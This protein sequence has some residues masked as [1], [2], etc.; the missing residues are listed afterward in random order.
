M[1]RP[2]AETNPARIRRQRLAAGLKDRV[3]EAEDIRV[4]FRKA[5]HATLWPHRASLSR[6]FADREIN[7]PQ[8]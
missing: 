1:R 5:F 2:K 3:V 7:E 6:Q 4:R 8:R